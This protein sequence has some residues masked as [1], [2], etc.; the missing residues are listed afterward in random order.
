VVVKSKRRGDLLYNLKETFDNLRKY[1]MILNR[2]KYV[3]GVSSGKLLDY[4]VSTWGIDTNPI[5]VEAI[6]KLQPPRTRKE[7]QKLA[8][9]MAT[10]NQFISKSRERVMPFYKLLRKVDGFE[11]DNKAMPTFIKLKQYLKSLPTL[12]P[13]KED[14]MLPF[15]PEHQLCQMLSF[16]SCLSLRSSP[17]RQIM[18]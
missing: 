11:W 7:I 17:Q 13:P 4:M 16:R 9:M 15:P 10:L 18:K 6:K 1:K 14:D 3:F 2:K 8:G 12:V 5:K